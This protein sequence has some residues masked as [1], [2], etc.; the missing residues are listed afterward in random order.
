[1]GT[2]WAMRH[3]REGRV[4]AVERVTDAVEA[5][6]RVLDHLAALG[7]D[8]SRPRECR[9]YLFMSGEL[10]AHAVAQELRGDGWEADCEQLQEVWL[11]TASTVTG[12]TDEG[13]R[14]TRSRLE[15]LAADYGGEY[16]G[17]EAA[18]D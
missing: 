2:P 8:P 10:N 16:D 1:M 11:V 6:S 5:D 3:W 4:R 12:L 17:W 14:D 9:H 13:V 7:C 18:A 15:L